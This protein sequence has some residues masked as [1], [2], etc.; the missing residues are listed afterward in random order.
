MNKKTVFIIGAG[1]SKEA[2]LPTGYELKSIIATL[3]NIQFSDPYEQT[4]GDRIIRE[5]LKMYV[6]NKE[7][8]SNINPYLKAA[9]LICDAMPQ[10]ISIDNF[11]DTH[12]DDKKIELCG[13]LAIVRSILDAEQNSLLY[14]DPSNIY[15]KID[16]SKLETTWY[17]N[18]WKLLTENCTKENLSQRLKS[19]T[20]IIFNYD[21]CIEHFLYKSFQNF[22]GL[23]PDESAKL[24]NEIEIY[25][26]YGVVGR[27][28]WQDEQSVEFGCEVSSRELLNLADQ[29]K[30]F[31]EGTDPQSSEIT[32]IRK[33]INEAD[34]IVFL[35]FAYFELNMKLLMPET[36]KANLPKGRYC[37]GTAKG[38]SK[39]D[40]EMIKAELGN[41]FKCSEHKINVR[42]D[43]DCYNLFNEYWRSLSLV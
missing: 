12:N 36:S 6:Q 29:I 42:N 3:L 10:S 31:T 26:P 13:K 14:I 39:S 41:L 34:T 28:P 38:I 21:R 20:L 23:K 25:H 18:F 15:N 40:C 8:S 19:I 35:G 24:V 22:Y 2:N 43:L 32:A 30:T 5:A 1:A 17:G 16:F 37:F 9:W 33:N 4:S 27:L 7:N 11:I